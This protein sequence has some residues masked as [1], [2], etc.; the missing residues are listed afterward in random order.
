MNNAATR[1][2]IAE[3]VSTVEGLTGYVKR[4]TSSR[5]GDAWPIWR[6][7]ERAEA[8]SFTNTWS[9]V[10]ALPSVASAADE[11]AD[12]YGE[13]IVDALRGILH[14]TDIAPAVDPMGGNEA[15]ALQITGIGE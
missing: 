11:W 10:V 12:S 9:V 5:P 3:A 15:F 7:A 2:A 8:W 1:E 6:G 4:P 13:A 14:V